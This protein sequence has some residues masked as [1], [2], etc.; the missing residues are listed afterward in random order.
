MFKPLLA[1]PVDLNKM[2]FPVLVSPKLDGIRAI[3]HPTLGLVSR[4]LKPIPNEYIRGQAE[5]F[6]A[7]LD[8]ELMLMKED[9]K[10]LPFSDITSGVMSRKGEPNFKF[11]VFDMV[12]SGAEPFWKRLGVVNEWVR[13]GPEN[14]ATVEHKI[15]HNLDALLEYEEA[16]V[17][18]GWEGV[19]LRDPEGRYKFGRST[20][21][22]GILLKMKRFHDDEAT[23]VGVV[24]RM[25]NNNEQTRDALGYAKRSSH[26]DNKTP[27]GDLGAL[28]CEY[29]G[30]QFE[31]G[32]G[33]TSH[34]RKELWLDRDSLT[35]QRVTFK[36][37]E[38]SKDGVPRFPVFLRFRADD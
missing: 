11:A 17:G 36:Y 32:T 38:I 28:V 2:K 16:T 9:G 12:M 37:Q 24:E 20:V 4:N 7:W 18:Q 13:N 30:V 1:A 31:L 23:V 25:I 35:G 19:M 5:R 22:E 21:N 14:L 6:P 33:F 27:A 34:Q 8:G 15:I 10:P 3:N 29:K 26:K